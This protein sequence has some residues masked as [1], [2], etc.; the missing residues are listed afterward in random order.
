MSGK[1]AVKIDQ[2]DYH[3]WT[4]SYRIT[5]GT[6]E[7]V[8]VGSVGPRIMRYGFVGGQNLFLEIEEQLGKSGEETWQARGGHRLWIAPELR[9]DTYA[10]DNSPCQV[11]VKR[12]GLL[13]VTGPVEAETGLRKELTVRLAPEG[14]E[15]EILHRI[16][17]ESGKTRR[18]APWAL[19]Q[20]APGGTGIAGFPP[21][22][23]HSEYL[24]PTHPLTMWGF[25]DFNDPRWTLT[26]KYVVLRQDPAVAA[27]QKTGL[28]NE[29]TFGAYL[30]GRDLFL[31]TTKADASKTYPDFGCSFET[32]TDGDVLELETLGPL[33]DLRAGR[34]VKH[35][36]RWTLHK[37]VEIPAWNDEEIDKA[38]LPLL[39]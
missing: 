13:T 10:L 7:L 21:R 14:T 9:P 37:D 38:L 19:T 11:T 6:V 35:V 16:T 22:R 33:V 26:R 39:V 28:F 34:P 29:A 25:T 18:L 8:V 27:A 32:Y 12:G 24:L 5:N 15:V 3:G 2:I 1:A 4:D 17:N 30:L 36:E 20:L 31:K 23:S